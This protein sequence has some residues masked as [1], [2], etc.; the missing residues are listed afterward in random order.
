MSFNSSLIDTSSLQ[1]AP[2]RAFLILTTPNPEV[3][4]GAYRPMGWATEPY[5]LIEDEFGDLWYFDA[6][7][8]LDHQQ[9]QRITQHPVQTGAN[10]SDHSF[11]LPAQLTMEIGMSDVMQSYVP[12]Q[13]GTDTSEPTKSVQV[14]QSL[15]FWKDQG[16]PL[17]ITTRLGVY[18][19]MVIAHISA[20]DDVKTMYGLKCL[21]T[22]QQI[23]TASVEKQKT[24]LIPHVSNQTD[25]GAIAT[26][27]ITGSALSN[28]T[29]NPFA[30]KEGL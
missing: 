29:W 6:V 2:W 21:V 24:S 19:N 4:E 27:P 25:K 17:T 7:I 30:V 3:D 5:T 11:A 16:S 26:T 1:Y 23:F 15:V 28:F 14:Y 8:R 13:W 18:E 9:S 22:F 20:P 12:G 10:I